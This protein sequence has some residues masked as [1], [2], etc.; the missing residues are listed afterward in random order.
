MARELTA[1]IAQRGAHPLLCVSH[2][3]TA[4]TGT[5]SLD[6]LAARL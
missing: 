3:N 2:N 1:L 6:G 4:L 5:A